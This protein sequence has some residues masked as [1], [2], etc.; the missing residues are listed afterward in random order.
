VECTPA[1]AYD[2][3]G[4]RTSETV[5]T[6][7][8]A[9]NAVKSTYAYPATSNQ[10]SSITP[11][12][13]TA[14][15]ISYDAA[16]DITTD[17]ASAGG[18][19]PALTYQYDAE[20]RLAK[21]TQTA[22]TGNVATYAYDADSR[23]ASRIVT[24]KTIS[25]STT[26]TTSTTILYAY[27]SS[28]HI[29]AE[30]N[31]SG[32]TQREYIWANDM[33]L[34]VVDNVVTTPVIYYVQVDH[35]MR[36][37]RMTD[38]SANWVWD[39]IFTP[40]GATAYINQNP[41]VMDARFPGQWFQLETGLAYNWHRHY[42]ATI[43]KYVQAD[44]LLNDDGVESI[45]GLPSDLFGARAT[46]NG[47]G[48][49]AI[50]AGAMLPDGP[51]LYGYARQSALAFTD[52]AGGQAQSA[53]LACPIGG[54]VNPVCDVGLVS[55]AIT[56]VVGVVGICERRTASSP[57]G[58]GSPLQRCLRAADG[59]PGDWANFCGSIRPAEQNNVVAGQPARYAC[60]AHN[61]SS[62]TEKANWC[63]NQHGN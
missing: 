7:S 43:G 52:P 24:Q 30:L 34:A 27:D 46:S 2:A 28:D 21:A 15:S 59:P 12:G 23:L 39:V 8:T 37:A 31:A 36:P 44:P 47:Y 10:L 20:G 51:S 35:L 19:G 41:T 11:A 16:G 1:W 60:L 62:P 56:I 42:D 4:N 57:G 53:V 63:H 33:P 18:S 26:T 25:G 50:R 32:Q 38:A 3:T 48:D 17:S 6:T 61:Y 58:A 9:A 45:R 5:N 49:Y 40:F 14:R 55:S 29:V 54:I 13:G 22:T